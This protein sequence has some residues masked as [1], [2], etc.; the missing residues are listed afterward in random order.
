MSTSSWNR[1][2]TASSNLSKLRLKMQSQTHGITSE[3][4]ANQ[5]DPNSKINGGDIAQCLQYEYERD[6]IVESVLNDRLYEQDRQRKKSYDFRKS[7]KASRASVKAAKKRLQQLKDKEMSDA[8]RIGDKRTL[9]PQHNKSMQR[10]GPV[11]INMDEE[12]IETILAN[13]AEQQARANKG[14]NKDQQQHQT[15][16]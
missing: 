12:A 15:I 2:T 14:R 9:S 13:V 10:T 11:K 1:A 3:Q 4:M 16:A 5:Q 8:Y 7:T 6:F